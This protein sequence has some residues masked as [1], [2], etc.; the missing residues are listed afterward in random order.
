[1]DLESGVCF[2]TAL[3]RFGNTHRKHD[4]YK[5]DVIFAGSIIEIIEEAHVC[6]L[7]VCIAT[8]A[9]NF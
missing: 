6:A 4:F 8:R 5:R 2:Y 7:I 9:P 1:M 3:N